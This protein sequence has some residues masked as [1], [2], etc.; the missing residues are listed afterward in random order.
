M[1][2]LRAVG[3]FS[4]LSVLL[5]VVGIYGVVAESVAQRVPEIGVRMAMGAE[6][7]DILRLILGQGARMIAL[8]IGLGLAGAI[9][10]RGVMTSFVFGVETLDPLSYAAACALLVATTLAACALPAR[11]AA[12]LDP[13]AAIRD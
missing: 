12:Q 4:L 7:H 11:R 3:L 1:F 10:L 8:G 13:A 9:A 5:A 6:T 2:V